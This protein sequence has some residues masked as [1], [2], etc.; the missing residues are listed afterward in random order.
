MYRHFTR[1][2]RY[3]IY[4]NLAEKLPKRE[5]AASVG[6]HI[7]RVS[8][9]IKRNKSQWGYRP[10]QADEKVKVRHALPNRVAFALVT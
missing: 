10:K 9:E 8:R 7:S 1:K 5:I 3:E 4:E 6:K 2:E